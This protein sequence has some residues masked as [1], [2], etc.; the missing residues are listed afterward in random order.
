MLVLRDDAAATTSFVERQASDV[1]EGD[2]MCAIGP[3]FIERARNLVNIRA[4]A[5][6]EIRTYHEEVLERFSRMPGASVSEKIRS[7]AEAMGDP[8]CTAKARYWVDIEEEIEK[9]MH[10]VVPHAPHD[11]ETFMKFTSALGI[12]ERIAENFWLW[13]IVAQRSHR[14]RSGNLFHDAFRGI[15]TD[16]HAALAQNR[17]RQSEIRA[18]RLM[19]EEHVSMVQSIEKVSAA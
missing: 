9:P 8:G 4:A 16:P 1:K 7:L 3:A 17:D 14:M 5:A 12:S 6:E 2:E 10:E 11:R 13:A 15:L 18:L 19:A